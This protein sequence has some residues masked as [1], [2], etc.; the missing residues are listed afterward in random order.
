M[1][2]TRKNLKVSISK[3]LSEKIKKYFLSSDWLRHFQTFSKYFQFN[4]EVNG[5]SKV[6][7]ERKRLRAKLSFT[8]KI[9]KAQK[10]YNS[11]STKFYLQVQVQLIQD[12]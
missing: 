5:I 6:F 4:I 2:K 9:H 12:G 7:G 11:N 8:N 1:A 10:C 3:S